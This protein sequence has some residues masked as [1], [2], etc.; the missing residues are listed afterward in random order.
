VG[1]SIHIKREPPLTLDEWKAVVGVTGLMRL[2]NGGTTATNPQ[3]G[4]VVFVSGKDGDAQVNI[5]GEWYPVFHWSDGSVRF[6]GG[7]GDEE[8]D[9][10]NPVW[11]LAKQLALKLKGR[12]V[13][14]DGEEYR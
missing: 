9:L 11:R 10:P 1:Y 8:T 7:F 12:L 6:K 13:G 14:D 5:D 4:E 3:T 2:D